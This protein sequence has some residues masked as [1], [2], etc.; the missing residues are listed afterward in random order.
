MMI[1][2]NIR[3]TMSGWRGPSPTA[4]QATDSGD[5]GS[6]PAVSKAMRS[7]LLAIGIGVIAGVIEL[8]LPAEDMFRAMRAEIRTHDAPSDIIVV[9]IDDKTLNALQ[10]N[11]P[12][13]KKDAQLLDQLFEAG[14]SRVFFDKA[15][16]DPTNPTSDE[17]FEEALKRH[18]ETYLAISPPLKEGVHDYEVV[19]PIERFKENARLASMIGQSGPFNLS[20]VFPTATPVGR[21]SVPSISAGLAGYRGPQKEYRLDFGIDIHSISRVSYIDVL[22]GRFDRDT[23]RGHAVVVG[24][25]YTGTSDVHYEPLGSKI[26]GVYFHALGAHTLREGPP[27]DLGWIPGLIL[28]AALMLWQATLRKPAYRVA[29]GALALMITV[30][31]I[32][33]YLS[34]GVDVFPALL[35]LTIGMVALERQARRVFDESTGCLRVEALES[36]TPDDSVLVFALK[37]K[38]FSFITRDSSNKVIID[39]IREG[40][41]RLTTTEGKV[42]FAF[43]KDTIIWLRPRIETADLADHLAGLQALFR[44]GIAHA[45]T[46]V[47]VAAHIGVDANYE[48]S[49]RSRIATAIQSAED[50]LQ[51]CTPAIIANSDYLTARDKRL[52]LLSDLDEAMAR[53]TVQVAYQPKIELATGRTVGAEALLRWTHHEHGAV[54][55]EEVVAMA[56]THNRID[57]LTMYV[58][59]TALAG[60]RLARQIDPKFQIAI[61]ISAIALTRVQLIYDITFLMSKHHIPAENIIFEVTETAPLDDRRV[62]AVMSALR[63]FG[64]HLSIDDFGTGHGALNYI[65]RIPGTEV[66]IDRSFVA[67]MTVS[68]ESRSVVQA[69]INIAH[70]LDRRAVAEGVEDRETA[71]LLADMGCDYAQGYLFARAMPINDLLQHMRQ[72]R[73][74]A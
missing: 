20:Y 35:C 19:Q 29:A 48:A 23:F 6:M 51:A 33:D 42:D 27:M 5:R 47:D 13:R 17:A 21:G 56:E 38:E 68:A 67:D 37:I 18:P 25:T 28:S 4:T 60:A 8:G 16:A 11:L 1:L 74:A 2:S 53:N 45:G 58:I 62:E 36:A 61:N 34:I 15:Y 52:T 66:K 46:K 39:F 9:T 30:P 70:S 50:A 12:D 54:P 26:P 43:H 73:I 63:E 41:R 7:A 72:I 57:D 31:L 65:K 71:A 22:Q 64:I 40:A 69:T 24:Q 59:D 14:A 10:T 49:I 32:M 55:P 3:K 44:R